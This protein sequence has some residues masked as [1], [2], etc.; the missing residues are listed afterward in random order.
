M[1]CDAI[2]T[3][4]YK[5]KPKINGRVLSKL[6]RFK[7]EISLPEFQIRIIVQ[8]PVKTSQV[9]NRQPMT[10]K[11]KRKVKLEMEVVNKGTFRVQRLVM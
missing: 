8:N 9:M 1:W 5:A 4:I 7:A 11:G 3:P 10:K 2:D 6:I